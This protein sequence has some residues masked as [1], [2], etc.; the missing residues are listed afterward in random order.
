M[1]CCFIIVVQVLLEHRLKEMEVKFMEQV[2]RNQVLMREFEL[3]TDRQR[4]M[5]K[6]YADLRQQLGQLMLYFFSCLPYT[7]NIYITNFFL[8][9]CDFRQ[10]LYTL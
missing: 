4:Y 5:N 1:T 2:N 6:E 9:T 8:F 3:Q 10:A 7:M